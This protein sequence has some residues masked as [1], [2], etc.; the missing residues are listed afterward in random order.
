MVW[1]QIASPSEAW[2]SSKLFRP[3]GRCPK[4]NRK[5]LNLCFRGML[6]LSPRKN[7]NIHGSRWESTCAAASLSKIAKSKKAE[8]TENTLVQTFQPPTINFAD[9]DYTELIDWPKGKLSPPPIMDNVTTESLEPNT[10]VLPE[11]EVM[12]FPCHTLSCVPE[13]VMKIK[14]GS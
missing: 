3:H 14:E 5:K 7:V 9:S 2:T 4:M 11:F 1:Y 12:Q 10:D 13:Y 8:K 6:F